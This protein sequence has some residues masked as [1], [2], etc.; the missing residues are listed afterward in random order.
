MTHN[1][2]LER[3]LQRINLLNCPRCGAPV[4]PENVVADG[5]R[6]A[7]DDAVFP[8]VWLVCKVNKCAQRLLNVGPTHFVQSYDDVL[9]AFEAALNI[10]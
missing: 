2:R 9:K 4:I 7:M 6:H 3:I 10:N 1:E 8:K 5:N